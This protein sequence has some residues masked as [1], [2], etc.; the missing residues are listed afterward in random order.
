[1]S[2]TPTIALTFGAGSAGLTLKARLF[3][4][5][6]NPVGGFITT[7]FTERS[8]GMFR[9]KPAI[10]DGHRGW[11]E[12]YDAANNLLAHIAINPEEFEN[13]NA[14]ISTRATPAD[15]PTVSQ[16]DDQLSSSHGEGDWGGGGSGSDPLENLVP[17][18]Y[19]PGTAG[20]A[21]GRISS[22]KITTVSPVS[23]LG[24]MQIVRG[25]DYSAEDGALRVF[26]WSDDESVW[27]DLDGA[28]ITFKCKGVEAEAG[29]V[30]GTPNKVRLELTNAQTSA[31]P[32]GRPRFSIFATLAN[33][34]VAT[35]IVGSIRYV[36]TGGLS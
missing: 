16:I 10:P 15:I 4:Y 26:E 9:F 28:I 25:D 36:A 18:D 8:N 13:S 22:A 7:G 17:G 12:I 27:P 14:K 2:I 19:E 31:L 11:L 24:D 23:V 29:F 20:A 34:H 21:L 6:E 30:A 35:L 5:D 3:D 1:M 33:E 32:T